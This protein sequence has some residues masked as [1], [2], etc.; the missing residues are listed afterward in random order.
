MSRSKHASHAN[1]A[2]KGSKLLDGDGPGLLPVLFTTHAWN[3]LMAEVVACITTG[4]G[5][6][7]GYLYGT[8]SPHALIV[9]AIIDDTLLPEDRAQ[10][11]HQISEEGLVLLGQVHDYAEEY[12]LPGKQPVPYVFLTTHNI[13]GHNST[14][15]ESATRDRLFSHPVGVLDSEDEEGMPS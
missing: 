10:I 4:E 5:D 12:V 3:V 9:R 14:R 11:E 6:Y 2:P 13:N 1:E 8:R 15:C 7:H